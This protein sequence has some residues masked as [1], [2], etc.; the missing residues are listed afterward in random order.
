MKA[1]TP[2]APT[3][4][5]DWLRQMRE[6]KFAGAGAAEHEATDP[7][8]AKRILETVA[9]RAKTKPATR[10]SAKKPATK[11]KRE[12]AAK[13]AA[14]RKRADADSNRTRRPR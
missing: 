13:T 8:D 7:A 5:A 12:P 2:K 1:P 6:K 4:K 14:K 3:P 9:T 11:T 10:A